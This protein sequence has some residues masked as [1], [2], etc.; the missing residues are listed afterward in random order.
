VPAD[1]RDGVRGNQVRDRWVGQPQRVMRA[2][3]RMVGI[4]GAQLVAIGTSAKKTSRVRRGE[5]HAAAVTRSR[6]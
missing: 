6:A 2:K 1:A 5:Q 3:V 4:T